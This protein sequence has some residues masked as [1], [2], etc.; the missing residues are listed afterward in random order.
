MNPQ[1]LKYMS[2]T[3][4]TSCNIRVQ[5]W[6]ISYHAA[7]CRSNNGSHDKNF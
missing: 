2:S 1:I 6:P 4:P 5:E 3:S 7:T